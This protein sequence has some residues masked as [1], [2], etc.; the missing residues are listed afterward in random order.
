MES[1]DFYAIIYEENMLKYKDLFLVVEL[2][3]CKPLVHTFKRRFSALRH[4][5]TDW[6]ARLSH[7]LVTDLLHFSTMTEDLENHKLRE[8]L[9]SIMA[10]K[11][12]TGNEKNDK[13]F[14]K[15]PLNNLIGGLSNGSLL[16][17]MIFH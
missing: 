17:K 10:G 2:I 14:R 7:N 11:F 8:D 9:I 13:G 6:R 12:I 1:N 4:I 16:K 5:I 15:Q 3:L